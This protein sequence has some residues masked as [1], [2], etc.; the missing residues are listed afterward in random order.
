[1][2]LVA[3]ASDTD[4]ISRVEFYRGTT[5]V[6]EDTT[7]PFTFELTLSTTGGAQLSARAFD[8]AGGSSNSEQI[9][10]NIEAPP[11][12]QTVWAFAIVDADTGQVLREPVINGASYSKATLGATNLFV[13]ASTLPTTIGSV[14]FDINGTTGVFIENMPPYCFGAG[15][16]CNAAQAINGSLN[17]TANPFD[18]A[19]AAGTAGQT[20]Q[21]TFTVNN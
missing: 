21:L 19:A 4:G 18:M 9:P 2:T 8:T 11:A 12:V 10:V 14:R 17:V 15:N 1:V 5:K 16:G 6:G 20:L 13:R 3:T 7:T